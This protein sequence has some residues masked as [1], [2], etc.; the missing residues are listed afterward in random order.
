MHIF[1]GTI[2]KI[3]LLV[4]LLVPA[5]A[6]E[7]PPLFALPLTV[8]DKHVISHAIQVS[9]TPRGMKHFET[10]LPDLF[11]SQG[12]R[13]DNG[14]FAGFSW[15]SPRSYAVNDLSIPKA[16]KDLLNSVINLMTTWLD[17][18]SL[19]EFRPSFKMSD[20]TY[21]AH[22]TRFALIPDE[23]L[24]RHL[25]KNEG[26]VLILEVE[27]KNATLTT[28]SIRAADLN[29][30]QLGQVG[31]EKISAKIGSNQVPVKIRLPFYV[32]MNRNQELEF[33]AIEL[34][35][36]LDVVNLDLKY[37]KPVLPKA[38][39]LLNDKA[40][41]V[42]QARLEGE[43]QKQLPEILRKAKIFMKDFA[44]GKL[45]N[46]LNTKAKALLAGSLEELSLMAPVGVEENPCLPSP[47]PYI[48]GMKLADIN[49]NNSLNFYVDAF[50]EDPLFPNTN[51][52]EIMNAHGT[53]HLSQVPNEQYDLAFAI[54]RGFINRMLQLSY[55]R[56]LF[57]NMPI[58]KSNPKS[59]KMDLLMQPE[60]DSTEPPAGAPQGP[61]VTYIKMKTKL[62][63]H[64]GFLTDFTER[65]ALREPFEI[66]LDVILQMRKMTNGEIR[67]FYY[68]V[69]PASILIANEYIRLGS[70]M[71]HRKAITTLQKMSQKWRELN[72][73]VTSQPISIPREILGIPLEP[74]VISFDPSGNLLLFMT[75]A[76]T[77]FENTSNSKKNFVRCGLR[78]RK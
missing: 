41:P 7:S 52:A 60:W 11:I 28:D 54:D 27:I 13:L 45:P 63:I 74:Q 62:K 8:G 33:Q 20:L 12:L 17:G 5:W 78:G 53:P 69:D 29:N 37:K 44:T 40:F 24:L 18:F 38:T 67:L 73:E 49:M 64:K 50:I 76:K 66:R 25:G 16:Q 59:A 71:V 42:S 34:E 2:Y 19:K 57:D 36:N 15:N 26:A 39:V 65:L 31:A 35:S 58:D 61:H 48:W 75:Y 6:L 1:Y 9:L 22:F 47:T 77:K 72:T 10:G 46:L 55:D 51:V 32:G 23:N 21:N 70:A 3:L 56:R 4:F 43:F 68:D 30:P 14:Y